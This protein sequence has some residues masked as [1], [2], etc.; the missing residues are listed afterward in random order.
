MLCVCNSFVCICVRYFIVI[1]R[2]CF[3]CFSCIMCVFSVSIYCFFLCFILLLLCFRC[4]IFFLCFHKFFAFTQNLINISY[5]T[6]LCLKLTSIST[7]RSLKASQAHR[8]GTI[9]Q[10]ALPVRGIRCSCRFNTLL[11]NSMGMTK[12]GV[13]NSAVPVSMMGVVGPQP[14]FLSVTSYRDEMSTALRSLL[15]TLDLWDSSFAIRNRL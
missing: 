6:L 12:Q 11:N 14:C 1:V 3:I 9:L 7:K 2:S 5:C 10:N 4:F 8:P 15:G 13:C